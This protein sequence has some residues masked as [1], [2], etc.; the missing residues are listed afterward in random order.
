MDKAGRAVLRVDG[1]V[2]RRCITAI[3]AALCMM[4]AVPAH[5]AMRGYI[6]TSFETI[7]V[8]APVRIIL[9]TGSG[10]SA[11]GEGE[12]DVLDRV[13]L[14]VSGGVLTVTMD[15]KSASG[16]ADTKQSPAP[17]LMLSTGQL[18]RA[19]V[20]GGGGL[21]IKELAGLEADVALNGSGEIVI[22][23]ADVERLSLFIGGSG[24][25]TAKGKA[26]D[27]QA[28]VNGSGTLD[29]QELGARAAVVTNAGSGSIRLMVHGPVRGASSGSGD[30]TISG[31]P[32]CTISQNGVG[33][34]QC[35]P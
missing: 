15:E 14:S 7:R 32:I 16:F 5:A 26:R 11:M 2:M 13:N 8:E 10:V 20:I 6:V 22:E 30:V 9:T 31:K 18:R 34:I 23:S 21:I 1:F 3:M 33:T 29:A 12:R 4:C 28:T 25:V 35:A 24:R 27:V 19:T 17:L